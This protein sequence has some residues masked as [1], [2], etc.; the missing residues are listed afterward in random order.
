LSIGSCEKIHDFCFAP[1][2]AKALAIASVNEAA[3]DKFWICPH[4]IHGK[5]VRE[6]AND[7][8][9]LAYDGA[10]ES[11]KPVSITVLKPWMVYT[12]SPVMG[13]M[14]EMVEMLDFWTEDYS[15]DDS[16][17]CKTF[18]V[19]ATAY[20]EALKALVDLYKAEKSAMK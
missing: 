8:A 14:K 12:L 5:T 15:V 19:E 7:I 3:Y 13:F 2:F 6:I 20:D 16:D 11:H 4:C 17:F 9:D 1:D 18:G 10:K